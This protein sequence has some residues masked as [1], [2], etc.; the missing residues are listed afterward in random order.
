MRFGNLDYLWLLPA[1]PALVLFYVLVFKHK[2]AAMARLASLPLMRVLVSGVSKRKQRAKPVLVVM[3]VGLMIF[4]LVEPM[5]GYRHVKVHR[6]GLDIVIAIDT[7][8]SMLARDMKPNRMAAAKFRIIDL[9]R[10]L[11]GDRVSLIAFAG[12]AY[13]KCPLTEDYETAKMLLKDIDVG[14]IHEGSTKI[15]NAIRRGV[16]AFHTKQRKHKVL[17]LI[18]DGEDHDSDPVGAARAAGAE[19][20]V[21][22]TVGIG[23]KEGDYILIPDEDGNETRLKDKDGNY[24]KS[25]L[26]EVLLSEI[27]A[28]ANAAR[29][30]LTKDIG[31]E[32]KIIGRYIPAYSPDWSLEKVY[33][34]IVKKMERKKLGPRWVK[35]F[36]NR[37][38]W[39][40]FLAVILLTVEA[41]MS[42]GK[43]EEKK[44]R[45]QRWEEVD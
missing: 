23:A 3:A 7:S 24:V 15:G 33:L 14:V 31:D 32:A 12:Q 34:E 40:L 18:T 45:R 2:R 9:L 28:A 6:E 27:P 13:I 16:Q 37:Y 1:L 35:K 21:I 43:R 25:R 36:H 30:E 10:V 22:F 41:V 8:R 39:P 4:A 29:Q 11:E 26:D 5:W 20:I 17:I 19:G 38:Q 44:R 42:Q